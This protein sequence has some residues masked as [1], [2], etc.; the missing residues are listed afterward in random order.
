MSKIAAVNPFKNDVV[1]IKFKT[2][3]TI[4]H[5]TGMGFY[6]CA[7]FY[8]CGDNYK[9]YLAGGGD[10]IV[11]KECQTDEHDES[12]RSK[13]YI[14]VKNHYDHSDSFYIYDD[15][16]ES[17]EVI[18]DAERFFS[19]DLKIL[20]V[21]I[22]DEMYINGKPLIWNEEEAEVDYNSKWNPTNEKRKP[23]SNN[24]RKLLKIFE[25]YIAD[26]AVRE[27]F[28]QTRE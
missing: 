23:Y 19:N 24:N 15:V 21:R 7:E 28:K 5:E 14:I 6:D 18:D 3:D 8:D 26:L 16:I 4:L 10:F 27:S 17:I 22:E 1:R 25:N 20:V 12:E 2:F 9:A 13:P 11:S